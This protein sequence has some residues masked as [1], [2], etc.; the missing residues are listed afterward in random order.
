MGAGRPPVDGRFQRQLRNGRPFLRQLERLRVEA[1]VRMGGRIQHQRGRYG[2]VFAICVSST[3]VYFVETTIYCTLN[4]SWVHGGTGA[5]M[6]APQEFVALGFH[7]VQRVGAGYIFSILPVAPPQNMQIGRARVLLFGRC[8][9]EGR[10]CNML[11]P[12]NTPNNKISAVRFAQ[13][14]YTHAYYSTLFV[15]FTRT[16][17]TVSVFFSTRICFGLGV[18]RRRIDEF[19]G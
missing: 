17:T 6:S 8:R 12:G 13:R 14:V 11:A 10:T 5:A 7:S 16:L 4:T 18:S 15:S 2:V 3:G 9:V 19:V 1:V